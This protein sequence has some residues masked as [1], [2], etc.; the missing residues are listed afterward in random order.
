M[1]E[2]L[3][4]FFIICHSVKWQDFTCWSSF[5][6][7]FFCFFPMFVGLALFQFSSISNVLLPVLLL[8]LFLSCCLDS[9]E[10]AL[11]L[12]L[13]A[14]LSKSWGYTQDSFLTY[15][16]TKQ[17]TLIQTVTLSPCFFLPNLV[18]VLFFPSA[19]AYTKASFSCWHN[20]WQHVKGSAWRQD[21]CCFVSAEHTR[22]VS[23][24]PLPSSPWST[25][26]IDGFQLV[27]TGLYWYLTSIFNVYCPNL[28]AHSLHCV[29][30]RM[31]LTDKNIDNENVIEAQE[32]DF[33]F[34][35]CVSF[36]FPV[37]R[38][39]HWKGPFVFS[40]ERCS[41]DSSN[42]VLIPVNNYNHQ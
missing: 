40:A 6:L 21:S 22:R 32:E 5:S 30:L 1:N 7:L 18:W 27:Y 17:I 10:L 42:T 38:F 41:S 37:C 33:N 2:K 20:A 35:I 29:L 36:I 9:P 19:Y 12:C 4:H 31:T 15:A 39:T 23:L 8:L 34:S 16:H 24:L 25:K 26:A 11:L 28:C 13:P 14:W 3:S